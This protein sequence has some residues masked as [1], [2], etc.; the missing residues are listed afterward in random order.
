MYTMDNQLKVG[1]HAERAVGIWLQTGL[2][3]N[4]QD[5]RKIKVYRDEDVDFI[6]NHLKIEV[7][8]DRYPEKNICF[9]TTSNVEKNT[10]GCFL[11]TKCDF[12]M[13]YYFQTGNIY[14]LPMPQTRNWFCIQ[15]LSEFKIIQPT[16]QDPDT[17]QIWHSEC[18]LVPLDK[19]M[20]CQKTKIGVPCEI[21]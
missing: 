3:Y 15:E 2:G 21:K 17:G 11:K 10:E 18:Y 7:K 13:Y 8:G 14:V 19:L 6:A 16:N 1:W 20:F 5:V 12:L 9:E 4:V